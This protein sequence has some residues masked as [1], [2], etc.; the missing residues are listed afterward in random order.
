MPHSLSV[1]QQGWQG[2][3]KVLN[4]LGMSTNAGKVLHVLAQYTLRVKLEV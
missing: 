1:T 2:M 3:A 4:R